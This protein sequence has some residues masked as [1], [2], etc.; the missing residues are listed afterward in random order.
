MAQR[1]FPRIN[2]WRS[3]GHRYRFSATTES[4]EEPYDPIT[5][6]Q[7]TPSSKRFVDAAWP[8][9]VEPIAECLAHLRCGGESVPRGSL[10]SPHTN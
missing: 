10:Q 7:P 5:G 9:I 1:N 4:G 8:Y 2:R 3:V 6:K